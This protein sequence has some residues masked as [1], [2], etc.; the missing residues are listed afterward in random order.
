MV[1][2]IKKITLEEANKDYIKMAEEVGHDIKNDYWKFPKDLRS[3]NPHYM[4][5]FKIVECNT[6]A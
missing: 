5:V 1:R 6:T 4:V 3:S 2:E